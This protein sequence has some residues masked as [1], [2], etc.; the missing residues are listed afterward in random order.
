MGANPWLPTKNPQT[1]HDPLGGYG[2]TSQHPWVHPRHSLSAILFIL[3]HPCSPFFGLVPP[4][5]AL[6]HGFCHNHVIWILLHPFWILPCLWILPQS[7]RWPVQIC[8]AHKAD[9]NFST[10][11]TLVTGHLALT[12]L[13]PYLGQVIQ[14]VRYKYLFLFFWTIS[15]YIYITYQ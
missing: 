5:S 12:C 1:T 14:Y 8:E 15:S 10:Y 2:L 3:V 11:S 7:H 4:C 13:I 9:H 6:F